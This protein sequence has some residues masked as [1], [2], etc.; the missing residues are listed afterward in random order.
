M[1]RHHRFNKT[2]RERELASFIRSNE[3]FSS[4]LFLF[5]FLTMFLL[6][7]SLCCPR[8]MLQCAF[9]V[10]R[11]FIEV[12]SFSFSL[13]FFLFSLFLLPRN[14]FFSFSHISL[15]FPNFL[16]VRILQVWKSAF[17]QMP[18][19]NKHGACWRREIG[20]HHEEEWISPRRWRGL[21]DCHLCLP[22]LL[23]FHL[24]HA[25]T[26]S[27]HLQKD[28]RDMVT[29]LL[30]CASLCFLK[31]MDLSR[32]PTMASQ[33]RSG[34]S[35]S[36]LFVFA[37]IVWLCYFFVSWIFTCTNGRVPT[38]LEQL[39]NLFYVKF[40]QVLLAAH[41]RWLQKWLRQ[42]IHCLSDMK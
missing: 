8:C 23:L 5:F 18:Y 25:H 15:S 13:F 37:W 31:V 10:G 42:R 12:S 30:I 20:C 14:S 7:S 21:H 29:Q 6:V 4:L 3:P 16:H 35:F 9:S 41:I 40:R 2:E 17:R 39:E 27:L 19:V 32:L 34:L 38:M 26:L 33:M 22:P 36:I 24:S 28:L 1:P 11:M